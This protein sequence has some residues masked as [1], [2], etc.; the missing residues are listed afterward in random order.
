[1]KPKN[2]SFH[3]S[4][5][6]DYKFLYFIKRQLVLLHQSLSFQTLKISLNIQ[7]SWHLYQKYVIPCR[8][9]CF[10]IFF[11]LRYIETVI[12]ALPNCS[13]IDCWK[14]F[15]TLYLSNSSDIIILR[16]HPPSRMNGRKRKIRVSNT[17]WM[18][19]M[20]TYKMKNMWF[21]KCLYIY[22][23]NKYL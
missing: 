18:S 15:L 5:T 13:G 17:G 3:I 12:F 14:T 9:F 11:F 1:M 10:F 19:E 7:F 8:Y 16:L 6:L 21:K 23:S 22:N 2:F 4:I 20:V